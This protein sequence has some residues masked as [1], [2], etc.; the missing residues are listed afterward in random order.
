M[1]ENFE[2]LLGNNA[3]KRR[4]SSAI[5]SNTLPHAFLVDGPDGAGKTL[6]AKEISAALCCENK[7][8]RTHPL[9]CHVCNTCRRIFEENYTDVK[10]LRKQSGKATVGVDAVKDF[11]ED[12]YL[13]ATEGEFKIYIFDNAES[14]TPQAQN[15]LLTVMEEPPPAVVIFLL[16]SS[17]DKILSTIKSRTQ[18]VAME[19]FSRERLQ[20]YL[21][22]TYPSARAL[23]AAD[24]EGFAAVISKADGYIGAALKLM[25]QETA[26]E[27]E[28]EHNAV[29]R[30][31]R[32][33][34]ARVPFSELYS[35]AKEFPE[36]RAEL[37]SVL[38]DITLALGDLIKCK[39]TKADTSL[40][41]YSSRDEIFEL[42]KS[43]SLA[44]LFKVHELV[45]DAHEK[46]TKNAIIQA[47]MASLLANIKSI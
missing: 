21:L 25:Q 37:V 2:K 38:E 12:M 22:D 10:Y 42:L 45:L 36:G 14:L 23:N 5:L 19:R 27:I 17:S 24:P 13:S 11:K 47:V 34:D 46:I 29:M 26:K 16:S 3:A 4:F 1:G 39:S 18:Y 43:F 31:I 15:A 41:F 30:F 9:P 32:A 28:D 20:E 35:V 40:S 44:K 8:S 33:L 6:F 7:G